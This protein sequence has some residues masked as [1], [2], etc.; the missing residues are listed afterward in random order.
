MT[1]ALGKIYRY[2]NEI[3]WQESN[4]KPWEIYALVSGL[5]KQD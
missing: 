3:Q 1:K 2:S 4:H 5:S